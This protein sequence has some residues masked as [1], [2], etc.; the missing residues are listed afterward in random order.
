[1]VEYTVALEQSVQD[2]A[3]RLGGVQFSVVSGALRART[4]SI[5]F[6]W[7]A[8]S[9]EAMPE[10]NQLSVV[11]FEDSIAK[12]IET[13]AAAMEC[14]G[15]A[16]LRGVLGGPPLHGADRFALDFTLDALLAEERILRTSIIIELREEMG[17]PLSEEEAEAL[18]ELIGVML[19]RSVLAF[20][21][22]RNE[23]QDEAMQQQ[24]AGVRRLA[25]LGT[26]VAG[27]SHDAANL[28]LPLRLSVERLKRSDLSEEALRNVGI[29]EHV[30]QH[31]QHTI[32][33]LRWLSV[34]PLRRP[35]AGQSL[36]LSD[37]VRE[38][39][40]FHG[41]MLPRTIVLEADV[42]PGLPRVRS[43]QAALSQVLFNLI[44]NAQQA[45]AAEQERGNIV[46]EARAGPHGTVRL[47]VED[48]GP[49]MP[50]QVR[51]KCFEAFFTTRTSGTGMGLALVQ[52]LVS[53]AAGTIEVFSPPPDKA[54]GTRFVITLARSE[55]PAADEG[56]SGAM[57]ADEA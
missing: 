5:L 46:V 38:F 49:G 14:G 15:E 51:A 56:G 35:T 16:E 53:E 33:N 39:V 21:R 41:S 20:I 26:L 23:R 29:I 17:R 47:S 28:L 22:S 1:M 8:Q 12:V 13:I 57:L 7:R 10:L 55:A 43:S 36:D 44:R 11:E 24:V 18:H 9:L 4:G 19:D 52:A 2:V 32:V 37:F 31:F 40:E 50:P 42:T 54:R 6:R 27:V 3:R 34:D 45:I 48:N 30:F 25:D